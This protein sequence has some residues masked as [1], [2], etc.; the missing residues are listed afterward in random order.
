[1]TQRALPPIPD[2]EPTALERRCPALDPHFEAHML[3]GGAIILAMLAVI[4]ALLFAD[5]KSFAAEPAARVRPVSAMAWLWTPAP[6]VS[7]QPIVRT[8]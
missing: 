8:R 5:I 6:A 4:G 7:S 2:I 1:M 3:V